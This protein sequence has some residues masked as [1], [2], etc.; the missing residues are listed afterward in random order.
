M[1]EEVRRPAPYVGPDRLV[2]LDN[3]VGLAAIEMTVKRLSVG[4]GGL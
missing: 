2:S 1:I 3:A 4:V